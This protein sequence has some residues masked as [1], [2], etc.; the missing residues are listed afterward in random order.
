[1]QDL[2]AEDKQLYDILYTTGVNKFISKKANY[3]MQKGDLFN[4][5]IARIIRYA[6]TYYL[7]WNDAK[8]KLNLNEDTLKT[9]KL[10]DFVNTYFQVPSEL[11]FYRIYWVLHIL[12]PKE[13]KYDFRTATLLVYE[14]ILDG[15]LTKYPKNFFLEANGR[16]RALICMQMALQRHG[17]SSIENIYKKFSNEEFANRFIKDYH[18]EKA[19]FYNYQYFDVM[20]Y[21]HEALPSHQRDEELY[22][23]YS[24]E[25]KD[26]I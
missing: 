18:L 25:I 13:Y 12:Y 23:K 1:M 6:C 7:G 5:R 16:L 11:A 26:E 19:Y 21:V 24:K 2:S 22:E 15:E 9:L 20:T 4:L 14:K 10:Y 3:N 17:F 8:I